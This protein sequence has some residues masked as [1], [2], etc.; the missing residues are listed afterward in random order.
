MTDGAH[1]VLSD[2]VDRRKD[3]VPTLLAEAFDEG[4]LRGLHP[5]HRLVVVL[6][7]I[8]V[9]IA[10]LATD[11]GDTE[12]QIADELNRALP[13]APRLVEQAELELRQQEIDR[14]GTVVRHDHATG[15][16]R[17]LADKVGVVRETGQHRLNDLAEVRR[18]TVAKGDGEEHEQ[19]DVTL[20]HKDSRAARV[21]QD[22]GQ[23]VLEA[24]D[25]E[26]CENLGDTLRR[27]L[28]IHL[29]GRRF[30]NAHERVDKVRE[31][32]LAEALDEASQGLGRRGPCLRNRVDENIAQKRHELVQ[33][34]DQIAGLGEGRHVADDG[35]GFALDIGTALAQT[36]VEDRDQER[37]RRRVDEV[38]GRG[39]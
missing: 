25:T 9:H 27:A 37:E 20:A 8:L 29:G 19:R 17:C 11:A 21:L 10:D 7:G 14:L 34:G 30:E 31:V 36:T 23:E 39:R 35:G 6:G 26:S 22:D 3:T 1:R 16:H 32:A 5:R 24:V 12:Q 18:E 4:L 13:N 33:V 2:D 28:L 15:A 38:S